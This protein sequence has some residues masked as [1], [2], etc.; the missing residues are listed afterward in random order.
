MG[1]RP[2]SDSILATAY[3]GVCSPAMMRLCECLRESIPADKGTEAQAGSTSQTRLLMSEGGLGPRFCV[4]PK[5]PP[6]CID[7]TEG[8]E[9][10]LR[11]PPLVT[12]AE[13]RTPAAQEGGRP[14]PRKPA[15]KAEQRQ[16][17]RPGWS[18][19]P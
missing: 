16:R 14:K 3:T 1:R 17:D 8:Q 9:G 2:S 4:T 15:G 10:P 7:A 11:S 19:P 5:A 18:W 6:S 13:H 12:E